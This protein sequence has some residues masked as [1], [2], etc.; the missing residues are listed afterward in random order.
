MVMRFRSPTQERERG[1]NRHIFK[2][3]SAIN[4]LR[5]P[6]SDLSCRYGEI[7]ALVS[8][9]DMVGS[10]AKPALRLPLKP[11]PAVRA[12]GLVLAQYQEIGRILAAARQSGVFENDTELHIVVADLLVNIGADGPATGDTADARAARQVLTERERSTL[13]WIAADRSDE[14][15]AHILGSK[16]EIIK[17]RVKGIFGKL[18]A[19]Y[20][21][22]TKNRASIHDFATDLG[23]G[24]AH[25]AAYSLQVARA[26]AWIDV[27]LTEAIGVE[28]VASALGVS[29]RTL[30]LAFRSVRGC[31]P[32]RAIHLRRL[33]GVRSALAAAKPG[34]TVTEIATRFGFFE[35]GRFSVRY[36][37]RF[38]EKP[39]ETLARSFTDPPFVHLGAGR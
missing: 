5:K 28:D 14:D 12:I 3:G 31:S 38:D 6:A 1:V 20:R 24:H 35:L 22:P 27:H 36:R 21:N 34:V 9:T 4:H 16:P 37:Q 33:D 18:L 11:T 15:I 26:E 25:N 13:K 29:A 7:T 39:S 23:S 30:R 32:L 19:E 2:V 8:T 17:D 10:R